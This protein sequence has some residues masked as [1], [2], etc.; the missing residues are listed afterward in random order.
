MIVWP[1]D[2]NAAPTDVETVN[3]AGFEPVDF[4]EHAR[5]VEAGR[6]RERTE[7]NAALETVRED[8]ER[9][10]ALYLEQDYAQMDRVLA[11]AESRVLSRLALPD[12]CDALWELEFRR[13]LAARGRSDDD[14]A[15]L[16]FRFAAALDP[17]RRPDA[18]YYGPDVAQTF[19]AAAALEGASVKAAV[20]VSVTPSDATRVLDCRVVSNVESEMKLSAGLHVL[21]AGAPG[22][23]PEARIVEV[24]A[25]TSVR[26]ELGADGRRGAEAIAVLPDVVPVDVTLPSSR[27]VLEQALEDREA[28]AMVWLKSDGTGWTAQLYVDDTRGKMVRGDTRVE[29]IAAA[30]E[31]LSP[32]GRLRMTP[33]SVD[34]APSREPPP[35][36]KPLARRWWF[37]AAAGGVVLTAAAVGLAVGLGRSGRE[38]PGR[39]TITVE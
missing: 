24:P 27:V 11:A 7:A 13:G 12:A 22:V 30:L 23:R 5:D 36:R 21:W 32:D 31:E 8:L 14:A 39:Q 9:V 34:P 26:L 25:S 15:R 6:E 20:G 4:G 33:P 3:A 19:V 16:R 38:G 18:G 35:A 28:D 2:G 37:W 17:E 29:A 10:Q 1:A